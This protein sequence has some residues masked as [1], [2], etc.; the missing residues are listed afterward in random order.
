MSLKTGPVKW[1][2]DRLPQEFIDSLSRHA[3]IEGWSFEDEPITHLSQLPTSLSFV[4]S[5]ISRISP[6]SGSLTLSKLCLDRC[7]NVVDLS[8]L[9][10]LPSIV[11]LGVYDCDSV[12]V[13]PSLVEFPS[14]THLWIERCKNL[15]NISGIRDSLTLTHLS[16]TYCTKVV[17]ISSLKE[18]PS[19]VWINLMGCPGIVD[20]T[21]LAQLSSLEDILLKECTGITNISALAPLFSK[22]LKQVVGESLEEREER[23]RRTIFAYYGQ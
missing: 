16:L 7:H 10:Y 19:L 22:T 17:D 14:I 2:S 20:I 15:E 21:G 23:V 11:K 6:I 13:A 8:S 1:I 3:C 4:H 12:T 18:L 9:R 5:E